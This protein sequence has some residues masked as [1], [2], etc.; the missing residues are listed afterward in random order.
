LKDLECPL[1]NLYVMHYVMMS[2]PAA[3][4]NFKINYNSTDKKWT[5]AELIVK[6]SQ[7]EERL[8]TENDEHLVNFTKGFNSGHG[9]S[10]GK[11]SR[12][13]GKGKNPYDPPKEASKEDVADKKKV[14]SV[15][16]I[17]N[18][19]T[20]GGNVINSRHGS[21]KRGFFGAGPQK[22]R[23]SFKWLMGAR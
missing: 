1:P 22:G 14:P 19:G 16:I 4:G 10:G 5:M 9:K 3:F 11:F 12:Q 20:E 7:E 17:R 6:L 18:M 13:K 8:R 23:E 21:S 15:F 2:L